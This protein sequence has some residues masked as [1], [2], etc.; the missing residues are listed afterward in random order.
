MQPGSSLS[1]LGGV[2]GSVPVGLAKGVDTAGGDISNPTNFVTKPIDEAGKLPIISS[3]SPSTLTNSTVSTSTLK[4]GSPNF[5]APVLPG[6]GNNSSSG[7]S[8]ATGSNVVNNFTDQVKKAVDKV[9]GGL[10]SAKPAG[11]TGGTN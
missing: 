10:T 9:T 8:T 5:F 11:S 2:P 6:T 4:A 3:L 7:G 1:G